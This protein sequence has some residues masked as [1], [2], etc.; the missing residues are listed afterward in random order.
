MEVLAP[1]GSMLTQLNSAT[2]NAQSWKTGALSGTSRVK[3]IGSGKN[4]VYSL[5]T[6]AVL[7]MP[8]EEKAKQKKATAL[9]TGEK[10]D[11]QLQ[12]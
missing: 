8:R 3:G 11:L 6:A 7:D 2:V 5:R 10:I 1:T 9:R 4:A 12:N